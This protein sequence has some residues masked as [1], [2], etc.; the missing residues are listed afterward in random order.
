MK[1]FIYKILLFITIIVTIIL[2]Q[3]LYLYYKNHDNVVKIN[4]RNIIIGDSNTRWSMDDKIIKGYS[5]FSTGGETYLFAET[6][7]NILTKHNK[8]DTLILSFSPHNII[9]N[10]WWN[11]NELGNPLD[12]RMSSFFQ[13][14]TLENHIDFI[15]N[16]P[17]NYVNAL[18]SI[19]KSKIDNIISFKSNENSLSRFGSYIPNPENET[20]HPIEPYK[21]KKPII[22]NIETK[23]LQKII[24]LCKEKKIKLILIQPPKNYLRKDYKNYDHK[25]FYDYYDQYLKDIDF[26]D[27][28]KLELPPHAYWDI[29]HVDIV[30]AKYFSNFIYQKWGGVKKLLKSKY[31]RKNLHK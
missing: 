2:G 28:S 17:K 26:L 13:D 24:R 20:Q 31:N 18:T 27:F 11:D 5:N 21:Y 22:T 16:I 3:F 23:Y 8:I 15:N 7:L 6:K 9:N 10:M 30:G 1:K 14:F 12:Y 19:G 29:N 4:T 25:E